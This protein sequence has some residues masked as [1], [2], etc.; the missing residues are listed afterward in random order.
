MNSHQRRKERRYW[1]HEVYVGP[2]DYDTYYSMWV[3]CH[4]QFGQNV[5]DG[6]RWKPRTYFTKWQFDKTEKATMFAL[7]WT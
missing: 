4:T 2:I 1:T 5:R 7:R 6:W 3:W